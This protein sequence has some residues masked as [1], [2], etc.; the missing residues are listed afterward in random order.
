MIPFF[1]YNTIMF[2]PVTIQVWGTCV[3]LGIIAAVLL[4]QRL[5]KKYFLS[6]ELLLDLAMWVLISAFLFAR[7]FHVVFYDLAFYMAHPIDVLKFWQGGAS[8][9]G[10]FFGAGVALWLFCKKRKITWEQFLPYAD[11][12]AV[13]LW[14]G[15]GIGRIGCFLI[16]DH[17]GTLSHFVGAVQFPTGAR[18]DLGLYESIVGF[19]LFII[20]MSS[21]KWLVKKQ[22]GLVAVCS[23]LLYAVA[24]FFLDFLRA[25]DV[26]GSDARYAHLTPAQWGMLLVVVALTSVLVS[27]TL[28][29]PKKA[30]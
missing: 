27:G 28:K 26:V 15:W 10:G 17:P 2:G 5:A 9:L 13:S 20:F 3:A 14:L 25:T 7:V 21:F 22:W 1:Q 29:R 19:V 16:H 30:V 23:S 12:A 6:K 18:H 4:M 11:V 8:S 24:R